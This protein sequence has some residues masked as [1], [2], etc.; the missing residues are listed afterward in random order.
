MARAARLN[1]RQELEREEATLR[2]RKEQLALEMDIAAKLGILKE[3]EATSHVSVDMM[4]EYLE[5]WRTE[6]FDEDSTCKLEHCSLAQALSNWKL[7]TNNQVKKAL[8]II[9]MESA[10]RGL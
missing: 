6:S 8:G 10:R 4:D 9:W 7:T 5:N 2:A 1:R 3:N